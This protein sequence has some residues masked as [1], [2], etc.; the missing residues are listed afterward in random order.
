VI[1][2]GGGNDG[3]ANSLGLSNAYIATKRL[4]DSIVDCKYRKLNLYSVER[5]IN[6]GAGTPMGISTPTSSGGPGILSPSGSALNLNST[7]VG[8]FD[9]H[10]TTWGLL[11]DVELSVQR[12]FSRLPKS[13][14]YY[15]AIAKTLLNLQPKFGSLT[16]RVNAPIPQELV[17]KGLPELEPKIT[18]ISGAFSMVTISNVSHWKR[19]AIVDPDARPDDGRLSVMVVRHCSRWNFLRTLVAMETGS[20][21][22]LPWVSTYRCSE[23]VLINETGEANICGY[24]EAEL[25]SRINKTDGIR[26]RSN[27]VTANMMC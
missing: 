23:V 5:V 24:G 27:L 3:L 12:E 8:I 11:A 4:I 7:G 26:F 2:T 9:F 20:H 17:G 19:E 13:I 6:P 25:D 1:P 21:V 22:T 15:L 10:L 18:T 16:M 14:R